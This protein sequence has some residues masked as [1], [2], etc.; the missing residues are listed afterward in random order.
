MCSKY[1][2]SFVFLKRNIYLFVYT[3]VVAFKIVNTRHY[4]LTYYVSMSM[5]IQIV[6]T[7]FKPLAFSAIFLYLVKRWAFKVLFIFEKRQ[8]SHEAMLAKN[9]KTSNEV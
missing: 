8:K 4:A 6:E 2:E 7:V 9:C 1:N 5:L 3:N